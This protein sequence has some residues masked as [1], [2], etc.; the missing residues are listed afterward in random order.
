MAISINQK[1]L[2][3]SAGTA[4]NSRKSVSGQKMGIFSRLGRPIKPV[5]VIFFTSQLSLMLEIGTPLKNALEIIEDQTQNPVFKE[6]LQT[7]VQDIE[8]GRQLSDAMKRHPRIFNS[9]FA[10]MVRAGETGGFLK[11]I[12]DRLIEIQ[13]KRQ[14]LKTQL[15]SA[16]TYPAVLCIVS[17]LVIIF[18][19]VV[20]L[21]KFTGFFAGKE[22]ILP[23]TTRLMMTL[24]ASLKGYW[25]LY[26]ISGI[27]LVLGLKFFRESRMGQ[28]F[29]DMFAV[30]G[31]LI[32]K[33]ANKIY[34][35]HFLRILG[36]LM[37]S[38]VPLVE[39]LEVTRTTI[40]NRY[41]RNFIDRIIDH[42]QEGGKFSKP[43]AT[44]PYILD[45]VKKMV[46]TGEET[47]SLPKVMSRLAKF[48]DEEVDREL[49][50]VA[51]LIEPLA[52]VVMGG[53][54]G[55]IVS[56]VI[57]PLFRIASTVH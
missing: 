41:F 54:V 29:I 15:R 23:L 35:C 19:L 47:G 46:A 40:T 2:T 9:V 28:A 51:T 57:L 3:L 33:L 11:E 50:N 42:V 44:Y 18:V 17:F 5:E 7:M 49:K 48:Y 16:L 21:P 22:S 36:N 39:S 55:I 53:I 37:E 27:G 8:E 31:P 30:K 24:S 38:Q 10:S 12:L 32:S 43:F 25:W 26:I 20:V 1:G 13:E 14:A 4:E 56:S 34:T 6:V 45:S 52:L